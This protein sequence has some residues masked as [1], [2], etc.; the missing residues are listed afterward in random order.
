MLALTRFVSLK[1][2]ADLLIAHS[3]I[4]PFHRIVSLAIV[5]RCGEAAELEALKT[6][7]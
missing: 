3:F 7:W 4:V 2:T 1:F 6:F 5:A